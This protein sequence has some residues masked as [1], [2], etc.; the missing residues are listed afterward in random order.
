MTNANEAPMISSFRDLDSALVA[1]MRETQNYKVTLYPIVAYG[2]E[3]LV[4]TD[5]HHSLEAAKLDGVEPLFC[6][7]PASEYA[8]ELG[9]AGVGV[10]LGDVAV[11]SHWFYI[12]N[13]AE[14]WA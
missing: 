6:T 12:D 14:V 13:G 9:M 5:G 3:Y 11:D 8:D 4:V 2:V 10:W 1:E 7:L